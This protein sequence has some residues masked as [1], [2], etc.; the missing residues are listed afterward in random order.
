IGQLVHEFGGNGL[1]LDICGGEFA[2]ALSRIADK[3]ADH[4]RKPCIS[5]KVAKKPGTATDDCTVSTFSP[6]D[7]GKVIERPTAACA[8]TGGVG[9]C[10]QL[11][12]GDA[13]CGGQT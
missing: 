2:G 3:T 1:Q 8:D 6:D 12:P 10:W 11:A 4:I 7:S 13:G 9:P 5:G